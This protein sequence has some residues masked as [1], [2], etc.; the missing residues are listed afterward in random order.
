MA[1]PP[2]LARGMLSGCIVADWPAPPGLVALTTTRPGG[3][4]AAPYDSLNLAVHVGDRPEK[5][6]ANRAQLQSALGLVSPI[7]WL[8]QVHGVGVVRAGPDAAGVAIDGAACMY[9]NTPDGQFVIDQHPAYESVFFGSGFSGHGFKFAPVIG[10]VL[11]DLAETG[12]TRL[13]VDF[14]RLKRFQT[15]TQG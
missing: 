7:A 14:L 15:N 5:V 3:L 4:S 9:T 8:D 13:P 1:L 11:A 6:A 2:E 12:S 10:A